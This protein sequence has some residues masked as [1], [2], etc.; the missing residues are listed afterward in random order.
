MTIIR[1]RLFGPE[2][3]L[4]D[5]PSRGRSWKTRRVAIADKLQEIE[6]LQ[7]QVAENFGNDEELL[8][9]D[10]PTVQEL[11]PLVHPS[12]ATTPRMFR[13]GMRV[14]RSRSASIRILQ[15]RSSRHKTYWQLR[16]FCRISGGLDY[17]GGE[18]GCEA[19]QHR[20]YSL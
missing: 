12:T 5:W 8:L 18:I 9:E 14:K 16:Q 20:P 13:L 3:Q 15:R 6:T 17:P 11:V 19:A 4:C 10:L 2:Q 1:S 7:T